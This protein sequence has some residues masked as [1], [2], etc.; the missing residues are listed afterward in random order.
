MPDSLPRLA[1]AL[2]DR[3]RIERELG[4]GGM[5]TVYLAEDLKH[6]RQVAIKVLKPELAAVLGAERFIQEIT[7]TAA[8]Q[9]PHILPLFDSGSADGF[10]FYVM[11]YIEGETLRSKLDRETQLGVEEAVRIAS[12][13]ADALDYAHRHGVIHR[14]IKPENILLHDGRPMVADF[15]IALAVSAAAGG[16]MTETGLSLGTPH[17]M[18]PE[19]A[20]AE[21]DLSA[22]SDVYSLGSVL[23]EMLTGNPP[24][25]GSSAQQIIMRIV[26]EEAQPVTRTRKAVPANVSAAVA[27]S[28]E[29]LP[30]D[31]FESARAFA[32]ALRTPGF[33][34]G[35]TA[36]SAVSG[37]AP[38]APA[39]RLTLIHGAVTAVLA[40]AL[41]W[42]ALGRE[43]PGPTVPF[44]ATLGD[45][46]IPLPQGIA[47][48]PDGRMVVLALVN[49]DGQSQLFLRPSDQNTLQP[50]AGTNGASSPM[51]SPDGGSIGFL[52]S[53]AGQA[54]RSFMRVPVGGGA[55]QVIADSVSYVDWG[56]DGTIVVVRD[57]GLY[58]I[59]GGEGRA[60]L[61]LASDTIQ[62][63]NP[64]VL[65]DGSGVLFSNNALGGGVGLLLD[66]ATGTLTKVL[67]SAQNPRYVATG[68]LIYHAQPPSVAVMAVAFDLR[69]HRVSGA[70]FQVL[71]TVWRTGGASYWDVS[72]NGTLIYV[73]S[74]DVGDGERLAWIDPSG[75][76]D[77][78]P[79]QVQDFELPRLS[80]D[81]RRVAFL[82]FS[83][84]QLSVFDLS[85][86]AT[87]Q[88]GNFSTAVWGADSRT[89]Y[90][91]TPSGG[92]RRATIRLAIDGA[93]KP[94]TLLYDV[95]EVL[96]V[97]PDGSR[98][99]MSRSLAGRGF[100]LDILALDGAS[101]EVVPYLRANWNERQGD[102]S[103]DGRWLAYV[104]DESGQNEVFVR[105]F[106]DPG[107]PV[108][109]SEGGGVGPAWARDG[110]SIY[111]A[112]PERMVRVQVTAGTSGLQVR[113][114]TALFSTNGLEVTTASF[115]QNLGFPRRYDVG[116][117]GRLLMVRSAE[118][119]YQFG[120]PVRVIVNWF[121]DLRAKASR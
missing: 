97:S 30:A 76:A 62:I 91:S 58:R 72:R 18:S 12:E 77:P 68:H 82:D 96:S 71:S 16:R 55:V 24:H 59:R 37:L 67:P 81:G 60:E 32:E 54:L 110:G 113:S 63:T 21:K 36:A 35:T 17:Y 43:S 4:Q 26:T 27:K 1:E 50:L 116:L 88:L 49:A 48:S 57:A 19:Q 108:R 14:D 104:S 100:D 66:F 23:Y 103:P 53:T 95:S 94:D 7:T 74:P 99:V 101:P 22:R 15:G 87:L 89:L 38:G 45:S 52:Q 29:K 64:D 61:L 51:F 118:E 78:L 109:I 33:T 69:T 102:I 70:P 85:T 28:L 25:V 75:T 11:P 34:H 119:M 44:H 90:V 73:R 9:H 121:D 86:G 8:L 112:G 20:T 84:S 2:K 5:A 120:V 6:K 3:Y 47:I 40:L 41:G 107:P 13:V 115:F 111:Y 65:P 56:E 98:L 106:P 117:D 42:M 80:P 83:A 10:L 105:S 31:R 46:V 114:R 39:R 79:I 92:A 93:G